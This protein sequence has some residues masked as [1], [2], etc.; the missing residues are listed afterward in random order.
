MGSYETLATI[1]ALKMYYNHIDGHLRALSPAAAALW[2]RDFVDRVA[3]C[4]KQIERMEAWTNEHLAVKAPQALIVPDKGFGG[5]TLFQKS[6]DKTKS[7]EKSSQQNG[8]L[9]VNGEEQDQQ[10]VADDGSMGTHH[11]KK[12]RKHSFVEEMAPLPEDVNA[13]EAHKTM[14]R[15]MS[16]EDVGPKEKNE[17]HGLIG[18]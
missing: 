18:R 6:D 8:H 9:S 10:R 4:Q 1:M 3:Y 16:K 7:A 15:G 12:N 14:T 11:S 13:G 2:D 5:S 17:A